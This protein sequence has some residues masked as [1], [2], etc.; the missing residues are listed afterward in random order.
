MIYSYLKIFDR[1]ANYFFKMVFLENTLFSHF[2]YLE[3][4]NLNKI[5]HSSTG[6]EYSA[7]G[8][9]KNIE[10]RKLIIDN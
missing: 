6:N 8:R 3:L 4:E 2:D 7:L 10:K 9:K 1:L 5:L